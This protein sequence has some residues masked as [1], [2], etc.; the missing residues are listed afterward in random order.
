MLALKNDGSM[1]KKSLGDHEAMENREGS[2][3]VALH[4]RCNAW[5]MDS[6]C[7]LNKVTWVKQVF[8]KTVER[9]VVFSFV[10]RG[11]EWWIY[12]AGVSVE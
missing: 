11:G 9:E 8:S 1:V 7:Q 3:V 5:S 6:S 12:F 4:Y 2:T 10:N